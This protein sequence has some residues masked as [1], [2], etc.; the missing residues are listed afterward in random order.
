[1]EYHGTWYIGDIGL[2][3]LKEPM[4]IISKYSV[5]S[6][7]PFDSANSYPDRLFLNKIRENGGWSFTH[8]ENKHIYV[9]SGKYNELLLYRMIGHELG[10]LAP[11]EFESEEDKAEQYEDVV[12]MTYLF[13]VEIKKHL[14][15]E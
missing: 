14:G 11:S 7:R 2:S 13:M 5:L 1:M 3:L 12:E 4:H 6:G 15:E 8:V 10:H 9:Y